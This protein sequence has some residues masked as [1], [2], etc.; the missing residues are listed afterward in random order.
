MVQ[1][2]R[3]RKT[4]A[5]KWKSWLAI[6]LVGACSLCFCACEDLASIF[7]SALDSALEGFLGGY[8]DGTVDETYV[9]TRTVGGG[10][11]YYNRLTAKQQR[12]YKK[13]RIDLDKFFAGE[14]EL[15]SYTYEGKEYGLLGDYRY[16]TF[17]LTEAQGRQTF[18]ALYQ[19]CPQYY[20][21]DSVYLLHDE[22]SLSPVLSVNYAK[23]ATRDALDQKIAASVQTVGVLLQGAY[24]DFEKFEVIYKYV[25]GQVEYEYDGYGNPS[26]TDH[27]GTIVGVLDGNA[28]T[29]S[30]CVGYTFS[31][32]YLCNI[33]GVECISV[34]NEAL[35]HA[36]NMAKIDGNWYHADATND[37]GEDWGELFLC[38]E[39]VFWNFFEYNTP[40]YDS[41]AADSVGRVG[42]LPD[43]LD[44]LCY[45]RFS[46]RATEDGLT[47]SG[48]KVDQYYLRIPA[49]YQGKSVH[50]IGYAF[51]AAATQLIGLVIPTSIRQIEGS[52]FLLHAPQIIFYEG[53]AEQFAEISVGIL[54]DAFSSAQVYYY[55]EEPPKQDTGDYWCYQDGLPAVW[56]NDYGE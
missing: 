40:V 37:D 11:Y 34:G 10:D 39:E 48:V 23:K 9:Y 41:G 15:Y 7:S 16:S 18:D 53:T 5:K 38:S 8:E 28:N 45:S 54:N 29:N 4:I 42:I 55:S 17:G 25:M 19:D 49:S 13:L 50:T 31:I 56:T 20:A 43:V 26:E 32:T 51:G 30:V 24:T 14:R 3:M 44:D 33:Y 21:Y 22:V 36:W 12:F 1:W 47:V 46:Y 6:L 2:L 35:N 52:A 27:A